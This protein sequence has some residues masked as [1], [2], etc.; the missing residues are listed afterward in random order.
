[1]RKLLLLSAAALLASA[2]N[3]QVSAP[4]L[5]QVWQS[6]DQM[7]S[8]SDARFGTGYNGK[9]YTFERSSGNVYS[10]DS[11]GRQTVVTCE[12]LIGSGAGVGAIAIA[13]DSKGNILLNNNFAYGGSSTNWTILTASDNY[14]T[15]KTLV[16]EGFTAG[17]L[18]QVGRVVGDVTSVVGAYMYMTLNGQNNIICVNI[19]NGDSYEIWTSTNMATEAFNTSTIAQCAFDNAEDLSN[20]DNPA[21]QAYW[22]KRGIATQGAGQIKYFDGTEVKDFAM[23]ADGYS[24]EGFDVFKLQ[25]ARFGIYPVGTAYGQKFA[26]LNLETGEEYARW[27]ESVAMQANYA[28]YVAEKVD[29]DKVNIYQYYAGGAAAMYTFELPKDYLTAIET[30]E[31]DANAPVEYYNLQGVKV[32]NPES[33]LFIK[34]QGSKT[35]KVVL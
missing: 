34:K 5:T 23:P 19:Y 4:T 7:P 26:I 20:T 2:A 15:K 9:V 21:D 17:R 14:A 35:T 29:D 16:L 31:V 1:M 13:T 8:N 11:N 30:V 22:R 12:E 25:G 10:W 3:A 24:T 32:A 28:S 27:E 6:T 18:D 33:G